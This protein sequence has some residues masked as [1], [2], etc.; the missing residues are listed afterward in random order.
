MMTQIIINIFMEQNNTNQEQYE[1]TI[2]K[3][4]KKCNVQN[5]ITPQ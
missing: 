2:Q 1:R 5:K 4:R 3:K